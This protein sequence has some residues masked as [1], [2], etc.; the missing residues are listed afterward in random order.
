MDA[1]IQQ[2][3]QRVEQTQEALRVLAQ[4]DERCQSAEMA[5]RHI[6]KDWDVRANEYQLLAEYHER[7]LDDLGLG[8]DSLSAEGNESVVVRRGEGEGGE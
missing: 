2:E 3:T 8:F 7:L 6:L 4:L 5:S 1:T